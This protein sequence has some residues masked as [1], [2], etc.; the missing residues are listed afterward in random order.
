M[1]N[2][3]LIVALLVSTLH[4]NA[5]FKSAQLVASGLTCSMCSKSI[6]KA[7]EK[8]PSV[9]KVDVDIEKSIF[10]IEFKENVPVGPDDILNAV[11]AAGFAVADLR[12]K[13][14]FEPT[15]LVRD[16][17][18]QYQGAY[19]HFL[20]GDGKS[21]SGE[22]EFKVVDKGFVPASAFK[23]YRKM[24]DMSCVETGKAAS[25]CAK[26]IQVGSRIYHVTL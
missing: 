26:D 17:H 4:S 12:I 6:F 23:K 22:Q 5:Q 14:V 20:N 9:A 24:T 1:K 13:A 7:L 15:K 2:I 3:I 11:T 10:T 16:Q 8:L 21:I 18:L 25:C 19:Y